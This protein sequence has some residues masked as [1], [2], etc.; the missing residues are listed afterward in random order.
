M[1][2]LVVAIIVFIDWKKNTVEP[3]TSWRALTSI[4]TPEP[5]MVDLTVTVNGKSGPG[6]GAWLPP[7]AGFNSTIKLASLGVLPP[8]FLQLPAINKQAKATTVKRYRT[9][10]IQKFLG[11]ILK[12]LLSFQHK[13]YY[14]R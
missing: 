7:A 13:K 14:F 12:L 5:G 2:K 4:L 3:V 1:V 8:P 6:A 10:F 9:L 11:K